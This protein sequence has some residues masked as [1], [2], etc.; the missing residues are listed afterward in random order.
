L[1]SESDR[2]HPKSLLGRRRIVLPAFK[3]ND[4]WDLVN[5]LA[6][7]KQTKL[8]PFWNAM[9]AGLVVALITLNVLPSPPIQYLYRIKAVATQ[10]RLTALQ[11]RLPNVR[12]TRTNNEH[13]HSDFRLL[14]ADVIALPDRKHEPILSTNHGLPNNVLAQ[15]TFLTDRIY[16]QNEIQVELEQ[17][18]LANVNNSVVKEIERQ[19][20]VLDWQREAANHLV[21]QLDSKDVDESSFQTISTNPIGTK[22]LKS[23]WSSLVDQKNQLYDQLL[24]QLRIAKTKAAGF[25]AVAGRPQIVPRIVKPL[26]DATVVAFFLGVM[27]SGLFFIVLR[28]SSPITRSQTIV[29]ETNQKQAV[30]IKSDGSGDILAKQLSRI[31]IPYLGL[32]EPE[33]Y[34]PVSMAKASAKASVGSERPDEIGVATRLTIRQKNSVVRGFLRAFSEP[35]QRASEWLLILWLAIAAFRFFTDDMWRSLVFQSPLSGLAKLLSGLA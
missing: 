10:T 12:G 23:E 7:Y 16:R 15:I 4:C 31:G 2:Y 28:L 18:S 11:H 1:N 5:S 35:A 9:V 17:I 34:V 21:Q 24:E 26:S 30:P 8:E 3:D 6:E 25:I 20:R 19:L 29:K 13:S 33:G 22:S 14:T 27:T 32:L